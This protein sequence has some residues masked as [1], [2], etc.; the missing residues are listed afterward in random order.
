MCTSIRNRF[1]MG[2]LTLSVSLFSYTSSAQTVEVSGLC[3]SDTITLLAGVDPLL[4]DGKP[5]FRGVGTVL[6]IPNVFVSISWSS[7]DSKWHVSF[8][9]QPYFESAA[10][11]MLPPNTSS[12]NWVPTADNMDCTTGGAGPLSIA[13]SGTTTSTSSP[14]TTSFRLMQN[15][16]NP[17]K[18]STT[19]SFEFPETCEA[20]LRVWDLNGRILQEHTELYQA[21]YWEK[22]LQI[23]AHSGILLVE[24]RTAYGTQVQRMLLLE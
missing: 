10:N 1:F 14:G 23:D 11:T 9:G 17:F 5:W 24:L 20:Q 3:I 18:G 7:M 12:G 16:P 8:D 15:W 6:G 22:T 21:G 13:G 4:V 19:I 2:L